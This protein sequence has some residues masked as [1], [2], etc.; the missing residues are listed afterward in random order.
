[1]LTPSC[2]TGSL[3]EAQAERVFDMLA[4]TSAVLK[5]RM[6]AEG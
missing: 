3:S 5:K 2:G 6:K 4:Q 1:M